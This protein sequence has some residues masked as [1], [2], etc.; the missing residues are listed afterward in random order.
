[1]NTILAAEPFKISLM[2]ST[3]IYAE[4]FCRQQ[5]NPQK[6]KQVYLNSLAVSAVGIYLNSLGWL[7]NREQSD[8]WNP[9]MQTLMDVADLEVP[10]FGKVEC[11]VVS[12]GQ[13]ELI[14]P[15]EAQSERIACV[16]LRVSSS[17]RECELLGFIPQITAAPILLNQLHPIG[18]LTQHLREYK[19]LQDQKRSQSIT[20][21]SRWWEDVIDDG[22]ELLETIFPP[23]PTVSFRSPNQLQELSRI[24]SEE[25][26]NF[27]AIPDQPI[28]QLAR[29]ISR[30]KLIDLRIDCNT[31]A[32]ALILQ[33]ETSDSEEIDI[34]AR[35][36]PTNTS[37][38][39]PQGLEIMILDE[40]QKPVLQAKANKINENIEFLFSGKP[41]ETFSIK[42]LLK[43]NKIVETF[44][45]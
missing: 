44:I 15:P 38:Y 25:R 39:L 5:N 29:G 2:I 18:N 36:C 7:T 14:V 35:I 11:R 9:L 40:K 12:E 16:V 10:G 28:E 22:W 21:L 23:E 24:E 27:S 42:A 3:R 8:S 31:V 33:L 37:N 30:V 4:K 19:Q 13:K 17:L 45:I 43:D 41:G 6:A 32:I 20:N 34:S 1:M 26:S